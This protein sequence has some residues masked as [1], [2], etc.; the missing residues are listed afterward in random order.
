MSK[1]ITSPTQ[2]DRWET[3]TAWSSLESS[4]LD[5][6]HY[7]LEYR[8]KNQMIPQGAPVAWDENAGTGNAERFLR[9]RAVPTIGQE[10]LASLSPTR[11]EYLQEVNDRAF[12]PARPNLGAASGGAG[13]Y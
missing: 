13:P 6:M 7:G 1:K 5:Q 10:A 3:G 11:Q 12:T 4:P 8:R 9:S 2:K